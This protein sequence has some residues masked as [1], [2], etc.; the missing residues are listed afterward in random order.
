MPL[1]QALKKWSGSLLSGTRLKLLMAQEVILCLD[2]AQDSRSLSTAESNL[3]SKLKKRTLGWLVIEKARK[4]QSGRISHIKEGDTNTRFFHLRAN[5]RRRKNFIQR[6]REGPRW[7]FNHSDKQHL[8]QDHFEKAMSTPP[9]RNCDF[10]WGDL[11]LPSVDLSSMDRPFTQDEVWQAICL[12]PQGKAPGPDGFTGHFF[13]SC[14]PL[15]RADVMATVDSLYNYRSQDLNIL[16]K[17]ILIPK[18]EGVESIGDYRPIILI[19]GIAKIIIKVL[20]LHLAPLI[21]D[22]ISPCQSAFNKRRNIH[23]NFLYV[24]NL[25]RRFHC[26]KTPAL[27]LKLDISKAFDSVHWDYLISLM[28]HQ[29]FPLKW[30]NWISALLTTS[31]SRVLLNGIPLEPIIHGR[32]LRQGDPF[33]PLLFILAI[34]PLQRLPA[35]HGARTANQAE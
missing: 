13:K 21:N 24:R 31:T 22:L 20:A 28:Q 26:T 8:I 27:L 17:A 16:N 34:D 19:H 1:S 9:P 7:L 15:I 10:S 18:Q 5:G 25:T 3:R 12:M 2:E 35:C 29:G 14:W 30:H 32:G 33:S 23:D 11:A 4:R 6:L